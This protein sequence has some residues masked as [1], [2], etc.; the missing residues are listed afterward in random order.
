MPNYLEAHP[1]IRQS[2]NGKIYTIKWMYSKKQD[3]E[4]FINKLRKTNTYKEVILYSRIKEGKLYGNHPFCVAV[5]GK[6]K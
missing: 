1:G 4:R 5:R 6:V 2:I 3:A